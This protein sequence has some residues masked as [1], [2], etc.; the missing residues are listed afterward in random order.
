MP[1]YDTYVYTVGNTTFTVVL[2]TLENTEM[3]GELEYKTGSLMEY[4]TCM[5]IVS[6]QSNYFVQSKP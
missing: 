3:V 1:L 4:D 5:N 6:T 2:T